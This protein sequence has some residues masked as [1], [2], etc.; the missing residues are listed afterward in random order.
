MK[1]K[2]DI[3]LRQYFEQVSSG[4]RW[5]A[6]LKSPIPLNLPR[7]VFTANFRLAT[8]HDYLREHLH[9]IGVANVS[10]CNLCSSGEPMNLLHLTNCIVLSFMTFT[11]NN[12]A[13]RWPNGIALSSGA[14]KGGVQGVWTPPNV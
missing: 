6:L 13:G 9:R 2:L 5:H 7:C 8:G 3:F 1:K 11:P 14:H 12:F 10:D 4:K